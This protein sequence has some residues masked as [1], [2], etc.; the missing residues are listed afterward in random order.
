MDLISPLEGCDV[1]RSLS[2]LG[3]NQH[4]VDSQLVD[5]I[6][7]TLEHNH[8]LN[9]LE[10]GGFAAT[11]QTN[12]ALCSMMAQQKTVKSISLVNWAL[13][14]ECA[15]ILLEGVNNM[16]EKVSLRCCEIGNEGCRVIGELFSRRADSGRLSSLDLSNNSIT[17]S[18]VDHLLDALVDP[19]SAQRLSSIILTTN[20][21]DNEDLVKILEGELAKRRATFSTA[22]R[23]Q[24]MNTEASRAASE[25]QQ[26]T[27]S[28]INLLRD[29]L[30]QRLVSLSPEAS[31]A[32]P[33]SD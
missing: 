29:K 27:A 25:E 22:R 10:L 1:V 26:Q 2:I 17:S 4:T 12:K 33:T 16:L 31:P 9:H 18:G 24:S 15:G 32:Q 8:T 5:V 13:K 28:E 11:P 19:F 21:I 3:N 14:P 30:A 6:G 20:E 7:Q 23:R